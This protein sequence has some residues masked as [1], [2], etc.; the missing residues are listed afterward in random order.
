M[1]SK[2]QREKKKKHEGGDT[3]HNTQKKKKKT[4]NKKDLRTLFLNRGRK[5]DGTKGQ[6]RNY[7]SHMPRISA[8]HLQDLFFCLLKHADDRRREPAKV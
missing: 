3:N 1:L 8:T 5:H 7:A 4:K 6:V 2:T